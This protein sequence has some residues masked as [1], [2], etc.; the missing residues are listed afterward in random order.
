MKDLKKAPSTLN[1]QLSTLNPQ[2]GTLH[3]P[4]SAFNPHP[5]TLSLQPSTL[6]SDGSITKQ[7]LRMRMAIGEPSADQTV[8]LNRLDLYHKSPDSGEHECKSWT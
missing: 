3:P 6:N 8:F 5:S 2:L 7:S 1:P 4:A